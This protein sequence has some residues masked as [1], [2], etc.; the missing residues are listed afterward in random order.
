MWVREAACTS[1]DNDS[2]RSTSRP[3]KTSFLRQAMREKEV[4][5]YLDKK[6]ENSQ[7]GKAPIQKAGQP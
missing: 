7:G 5:N 4:A 6:H 2:V 1:R 3:A